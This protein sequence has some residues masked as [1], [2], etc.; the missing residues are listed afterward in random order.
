MFDR[1][2][3]EDPQQGH[4]LV[5]CSFNRNF[6]KK[7]KRQADKDNGKK[8]IKEYRREKQITKNRREKRDQ[9]ESKRNDRSQGI[10]EKRQIKENRREMTDQREFQR[11][12]RS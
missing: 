6:S 9:R 11:N 1:A 8:E 5:A 3:A 10:D 12:D 2:A 7:Y 4:Q